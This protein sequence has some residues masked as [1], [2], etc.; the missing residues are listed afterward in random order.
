MEECSSILLLLYEVWSAAINIIQ[1]EYSSN[2]IIAVIGTHPSVEVI[3]LSQLIMQSSRISKYELC[4]GAALLRVQTHELIAGYL[5]IQ[6]AKQCG[7]FDFYS[8]P[9]F[10]MISLSI[11]I[12]SY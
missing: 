11:S 10:C 2:S 8:F 4:V 12:F 7:L 3:A 1:K 6:L 9:E 5:Q